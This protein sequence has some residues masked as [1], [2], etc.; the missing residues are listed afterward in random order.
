MRPFH[1][2]GAAL[3]VA[4]FV[5]CEAD[6]AGPA[7]L[8]VGESSGSVP[9]AAEPEEAT[10]AGPGSSPSEQTAA[11]QPP[12]EQGTV[13]SE[14]GASGGA[15]AGGG[16]AP[17]TGTE[18]PAISD[19]KP[20]SCGDAPLWWQSGPGVYTDTAPLFDFSPNGALLVR[21][22]GFGGEV[23]RVSSGEKVG[24]VDLNMAQDTVAGWSLVAG[25]DAYEGRV[26]VHD[27]TTGEVHF[28]VT[29]PPPDDGQWYHNG[30]AA[31]TPDGSR[32]VALSCWERY[33]GADPTL[34]L[35]VWD[36]A[37]YEWMTPVLDIEIP[38]GGDCLL[39]SALMTRNLKLLPD[40]SGALTAAPGTGALSF[41]ELD[42]G[43]VHPAPFALSPP[44]ITKPPMAYL[45]TSHYLAM[46]L[47]PDGTVAAVVGEDGLLRL[48]SL[49]DLSEIGAP[50]P[51]LT[52]VA[53]ACTYLPTT[54]SPVAISDDGAFLAHTGSDGAVVVRTLPAL[55]VVATLAAP[56]DPTQ[57]GEIYELRVPQTIRFSPDDARIAIGYEDGVALWGCG[58]PEP[59]TGAPLEPQL[60]GPST[61]DPGEPGTFTVW[62]NAG[63]LATVTVKQW[64]VDG[65]PHG[66][67]TLGGRL[68]LTLDPGN[69]TIAV[70]LDDGKT[71]A[72]AALQ[73]TAE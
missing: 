31:I 56:S 14:P 54:E 7:S 35:T 55:D 57:C 22:G 64:T 24:S 63:G 26:D 70:V 38:G 1:W 32:M 2:F 61:L 41:V 16:E 21:G 19:P 23:R 28:S 36:E 58:E 4:L 10:G 66:Y 5:G 39:D 13:D 48:L 42:S 71:T 60:S 15:P 47:S 34:R 45:Y 51:V 12:A 3:A 46:A 69:H 20:L 8:G 25:P 43:L 67:P 18:T 6:D 49:P 62:D 72:S 37:C 17:G 33:G 30:A 52:G 9:R 40:G 73:V 27:M 65:A 53:N 50:I 44:A 11:D 59:M 68:V 29:A